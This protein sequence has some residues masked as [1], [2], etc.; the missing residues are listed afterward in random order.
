MRREEGWAVLRS[1]DASSL[2]TRTLYVN[3]LGV[4]LSEPQR[5]QARVRPACLRLAS[6]RYRR[7][8]TGTASATR[9]PCSMSRLCHRSEMGSPTWST[10]RSAPVLHGLRVTLP[11]Q[12]RPPRATAIAARLQGAALGPAD[13]VSCWPLT[14]VRE[15][16]PFGIGAALVRVH[17]RS[18]DRQPFTR[19]T[20]RVPGVC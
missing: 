11:V 13:R 2:A 9:Y 16:G 6:P 12:L 7:V 19:I 18:D 5:L 4:A 14:L 15:V 1:D 3:R 8:R 10:T 20:E 17:R